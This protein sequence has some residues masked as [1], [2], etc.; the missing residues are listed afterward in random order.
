MATENEATPPA[1]TR[2]QVSSLDLF[3]FDSHDEETVLE[4]PPPEAKPAPAPKPKVASDATPEPKAA[5]KPKLPAWLD[6]QVKALEIPDHIAAKLDADELGQFVAATL[7]SKLKDAEGRA[8]GSA[9]DATPKPEPAEKPKPPAFDWGK[10]S[11]GS[12]VV[13]DEDVHPILLQYLPGLV[14]QSKRIEELEALVA[15]LAANESAR[16]SRRS[17]SVADQV[18][19]KYPKVF[20]EGNGA[21]IDKSSDFF[22][23]RQT[24]FVA[25]KAMYD[26][27]PEAARRATGMTPQVALEKMAKSLFGAAEAP[28]QEEPPVANPP[29]KGGRPTQEEWDQGQVNRPTKRVASDATRGR[30]AAIGELDKLLAQAPAE[31]G[32]DE[33]SMDEF[34]Q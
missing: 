3:D 30:T 16:I 17:D 6:A 33:T 26:A 9:A 1:E 8:K 4:L 24:C 27:V 31:A 13:P 15:Q 22:Q 18:F 10:N 14:A 20:G 28:K 2:T 25:A 12:P 32:E 21:S 29:K 23:R 19:A 34:F 5:E 7:S 11:D